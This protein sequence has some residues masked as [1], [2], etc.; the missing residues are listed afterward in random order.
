MCQINMLN[1]LHNI[2]CQFYL[3]K[4]KFKKM[5]QACWNLEVLYIEIH[6]FVMAECSATR[7]SSR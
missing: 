4:S 5:H 2:V 7:L 3:N 1:N 6:N